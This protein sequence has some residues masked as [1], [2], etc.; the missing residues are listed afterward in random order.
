MP[1]LGVI[2]HQVQVKSLIAKQ[3]LGAF[4]LRDLVCYIKNIKF[5]RNRFFDTLNVIF[6]K[7]HDT[8]ADEIRDL[9]PELYTAFWRSQARFDT[10]V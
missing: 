9:S 5:R 8:Q 6:V 4:D 3:I 10:C 7:A 1:F 2:Q